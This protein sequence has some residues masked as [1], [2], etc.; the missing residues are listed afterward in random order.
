MPLPLPRM[1]TQDMPPG[2]IKCC[3]QVRQAKITEPTIFKA[4]IPTFGEL[5]RS[6]V[7]GEDQ[8]GRAGP[9]APEE[10]V[11]II[12]ILEESKGYGDSGERQAR[13]LGS[14]Q[15]NGCLRSASRC[16]QESTCIPAEDSREGPSYRIPNR[17]RT[18]LVQAWSPPL[19]GAFPSCD[20]PTPCA[21]NAQCPIF[22]VLSRVIRTRETL[23]CPIKVSAVAAL[24][25]CTLDG[26]GCISP[27]DTDDFFSGY[28][29]TLSHLSS[30]SEVSGNASITGVSISPSMTPFPINLILWIH[31]VN[32]SR[33]VP[34]LPKLGQPHVLPLFQ[35]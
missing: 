18:C 34:E 13:C 14:I 2:A 33:I 25:S 5:V 10:C 1:Q 24:P 20:S 11:D 17:A 31:T 27:P 29:D 9:Y 8:Q 28:P 15:S 26:T 19:S 12:Q 21:T 16:R 23:L 35:P 30:E 22:G 32:N 6:H 3:N 4:G 7:V